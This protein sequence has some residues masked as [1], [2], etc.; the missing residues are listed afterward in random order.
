MV[1]MPTKE[2]KQCA[3]IK[4]LSEFAIRSSVA[5]GRQS[6]C[7]SCKAVRYQENRDHIR[8]RQAETWKQYSVNNRESLK[9]KG[10]AYRKNNSEQ[11]S[12]YRAQYKIDFAP[13]IA[14]KNAVWSK[15]LTGKIM[16]QPCEICGNRTA[17]AH[18]DDYAQPLSVRWL[19][20]RHH[21]A[22]HAENGEAPNG[23][24]AL[25]AAG[26]SLEAK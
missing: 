25:A 6:E 24:T 9:E 20:R 21:S 8:S 16:K 22:W 5:D 10:R 12:A 17:D 3:T 11:A 19:C 23:R 14:A 4:P 15:I 26:V 13:K 2:C 1:P 18:H 7:K